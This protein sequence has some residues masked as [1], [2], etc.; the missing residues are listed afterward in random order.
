MSPVQNQHHEPGTEQDFQ[1]VIS[2]YFKQMRREC[3]AKLL[4]NDREIP[5]L[6]K[7]SVDQSN[8]ISYIRTLNPYTQKKLLHWINESLILWQKAFVFKSFAKT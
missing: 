7:F 2:L 4:T 6:S 8:I 5:S 3:K 1:P